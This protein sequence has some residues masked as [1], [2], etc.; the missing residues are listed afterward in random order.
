MSEHKSK[1]RRAAPVCYGHIGGLL[2]EALF[3]LFVERGWLARDGQSITGQG[4]EGFG[5]L[6]VPVER[7]STSKRK[8]VNG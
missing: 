1:P 3:K 7:L 4:L 5:E 6:G 2:G 8:P